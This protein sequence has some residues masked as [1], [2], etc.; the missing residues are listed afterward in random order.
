MSRK[1]RVALVHDH[2]VQDGGAEQVLRVFMRMWPEAPVYTA[3]FDPVRMG[4]DFAKQ[5]IR[6]SFL[7]DLPLA[8]RYYKWTL[9]WLDGAFRR[10][11]LSDYDIVLSSA[12]GWAKSVRTGPGTLHVCYCHNPIRYIWSDVDRYITEN[13]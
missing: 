10:F 2:L 9:R 8:R 13:G 4:K 7:D 11:D 12:S 3:F 5:D 1:L 6:T